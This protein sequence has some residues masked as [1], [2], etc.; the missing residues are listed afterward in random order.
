MRLSIETIRVSAS[1]A[2]AALIRFYSRTVDWLSVSSNLCLTV[3][4]CLFAF[5]FVTWVVRAPGREIALF[6]P[7]SA[8]VS[9]GEP[10]LVSRAPNREMLAELVASEVLLGPSDQRFSAPF[11]SNERPGTVMLR[12]DK[13]YVDLAERVAL[14]PPDRLRRGIESLERS[15]RLA[16]P[17]LKTV[18]ITIGGRE[19]Y[20]SGLPR[21]SESARKTQ[22][23]N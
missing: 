9:R 12:D 1:S 22:E 3:L 2:V 21:E 17:G 6:F 11:D 4:T 18:A 16:L 15:L 8:G 20:T 7:D 10:R 19:P 13:L 23:N 14:T 5:S